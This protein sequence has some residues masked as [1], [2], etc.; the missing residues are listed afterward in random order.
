METLIK[1]ARAQI[2]DWSGKY[3][4]K[5]TEYRKMDVEYAEYKQVSTTTIEELETKCA[6]QAA[7]II[8]LSEFIA[9]GSVGTGNLVDDQQYCKV[10]QELLHHER[11]EI[12]D[13]KSAI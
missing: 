10:R 3:N 13:F 8:K 12:M 6:E 9:N 2:L 7:K 4:T 11:L 5:C 1:E